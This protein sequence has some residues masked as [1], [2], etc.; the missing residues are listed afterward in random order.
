V[1]EAERYAE[2]PE[3]SATLPA[4]AAGGSTKSGEWMTVAPAEV[5]GKTFSI[6][7]RGYEKAEVDEFLRAIAD[8]YETAVAKIALAAGEDLDPE[9]IGKEVKDILLAAHNTAERMKTK[10]RKEAEE[11]VRAATTNKQRADEEIERITRAADG[12]LVAAKTE[13]ERIESEAQQKASRETSKEIEQAKKYARELLESAER[14]AND[15]A[16]QVKQR[17]DVQRQLAGEMLSKIGKIDGLMQKLRE[18]FEIPDGIVLSDPEPS[19]E[20]EPAR[21]LERP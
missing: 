18:Q 13:A 6:V 4:S 8:D 17:E 9:S 1:E 7:R 21:D 20:R 14:R 5:V 16:A 11:L 15:L 12:K 2:E 10:A 19:D 3:E